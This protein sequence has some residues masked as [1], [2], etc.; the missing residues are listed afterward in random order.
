MGLL[1]EMILT[2]MIGKKIVYCFWDK[3]KNLLSFVTWDLKME[4]L[5]EKIDYNILGY[6]CRCGKQ[7]N[8]G[9]FTI[10]IGV[11]INIK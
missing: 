8:F 4:V 7:N 2:L 5:N 10:A 9:I 1:T 11:L 6:K 3:R